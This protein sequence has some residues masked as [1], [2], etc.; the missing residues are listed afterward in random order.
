MNENITYFRDNFGQ[1]QQ[2][3][4]NQVNNDAVPFFSPEDDVIF[5]LYTLTNP[6]EPQILS[7][8]NYSTILS[9]N[10]N[11]WKPTRIFIHGW[12]SRLHSEFTD[13]YLVKAKHNV[14]LIG[15]NWGK[16]SDTI[17]YNYARG[18]VN[19][20]AERVALFVDFMCRKKLMK[21]KD[22]TII[23]WYGI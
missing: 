10:F 11:W 22:L 14:N 17:F 1:L 19:D 20:V 6:T 5:E 2:I 18:R 12:N 3:D 8:S 21:T 4:I 23:G 9:S 13:A 16:G 7:I 15:V